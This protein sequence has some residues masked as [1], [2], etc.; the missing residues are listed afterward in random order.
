MMCLWIDDGDRGQPQQ[1]LLKVIDIQYC[2]LVIGLSLSFTDKNQLLE[3]HH[4][5]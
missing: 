2:L 3:Q 5:K 4:P 1:G